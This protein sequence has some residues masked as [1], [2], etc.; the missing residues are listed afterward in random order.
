M[1]GGAQVRRLGTWLPD[2]HLLM[3][4]VLDREG[5]RLSEVA[6]RALREYGG[7]EIP[8]ANENGPNFTNDEPLTVDPTLGSGFYALA[9]K[10]AN[11]LGD[12]WYPFGEWLSYS[13]VFVSTS[14]WLVATGL[15]WIWEFG[16]SVEESIEFAIMAHR[17]LRCLKVL[18]PGAEP[19]PPEEWS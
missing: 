3:V 15:G 13:S 14:G 18:T 2:R 9:E 8:P 11:E 12:D 19:W 16:K 7:L 10:L 5:Y 6:S 17:P 1:V 4:E